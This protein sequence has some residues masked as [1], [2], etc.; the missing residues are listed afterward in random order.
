MNLFAASRDRGHQDEDGRQ[1]PAAPRDFGH[2]LA[3]LA[4]VGLVGI[5]ASAVTFS[6]VSTYRA[7]EPFLRGM[8]WTVAAVL[9]VLLLAALVAERQAG[10]GSMNHRRA[11]WIGYG[12]M[13]ASGV[14]VLVEVNRSGTWTD[15]VSYAAP[16]LM[17]LAKVLYQ[18]LAPMLTRGVSAEKRRELRRRRQERADAIAD[19]QNELTER[20]EDAQL[21]AQAGRH[22]ARTESAYVTATAKANAGLAKTYEKRRAN[23]TRKPGVAIP[24]LG[25]WTPVSPAVSP[26]SLPQ[27]REGSPLALPPRSPG[28]G[29]AQDTQVNAGFDA[30]GHGEDTD[31]ID[32]VALHAAAQVA[33]VEMPEPDEPLNDEQLLLVL[34]HLRHSTNPP[35]SYRQALKAF[36]KARFVGKEERIRKAWAALCND[37]EAQL[38]EVTQ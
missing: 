22:W 4:H 21:A 5:L 36:R 9:D 31:G 1:P 10:P 6:T 8:S 28:A 15:P 25:D 16:V 14:L 18:F 2:G 24:V 11:Q 37:E 29:H 38:D 34:R 17:V 19:A 27:G 23:M 26:V 20:V 12:V 35:R 30:E 13:A 33:G 3:V 32:L 7:M